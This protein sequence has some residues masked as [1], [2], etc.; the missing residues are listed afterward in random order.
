M[1]RPLVTEILFYGTIAPGVANH[2]P[3]LP[4]SSVQ[5]ENTQANLLP[6]LR[7]HALPLS[8]DLICRQ[9]TIN[10]G[11]SLLASDA[12]RS[13]GSLDAQFFPPLVDT[14]PEPVSPKRNRDIFEE[15]TIANKKA[16]GKGGVGVAAAAAR[17]NDSQFLSDHRKSFS[18]ESNTSRL[19][20][21]RPPSANGNLTRPSSRHLSRS[22]SISS[23]VGPL[24]R[25]ILPDKRSNLSRVATVSLQAEEPTTESRNKE[26]LAKVVMA[27]MRMYGLQQRKK[28]QRASMAPNSDETLKTRDELAPGDAAKDEEY[29]IVYH[30]T[31]KGAAFAL[32][33]SLGWLR[34]CNS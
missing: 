28:S 34:G 33:S 2:S 32:V 31:F 27:A 4:A 24:S 9:Y 1:R 16:R 8:S 30:Q 25:K 19:P 17:G 18:I 6:E 3:T 13:V 10:D 29:K 20:E 21:V 5:V 12:A 23:E 11:M 15:A 26:A 7:V 14:K 22:P